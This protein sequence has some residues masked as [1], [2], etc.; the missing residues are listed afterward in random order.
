M[1]KIKNYKNITPNK[2]LKQLSKSLFLKLK[3][4]PRR[5]AI[6]VKIRTKYGKKK[7]IL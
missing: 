6:F 7:E 3:L 2:L 5:N 4:T 1:K